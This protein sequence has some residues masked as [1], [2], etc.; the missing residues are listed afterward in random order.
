MACNTRGE[1]NTLVGKGADKS[2]S[3]DIGVDGRFILKLVLE[4]QVLIGFI[5]LRAGSSYALL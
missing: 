1:D 3:G 4:E 2:P 5:W